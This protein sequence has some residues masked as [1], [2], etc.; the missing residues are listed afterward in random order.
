MPVERLGTV[1][2]LL[3]HCTLLLLRLLLLQQ[4]QCALLLE[5]SRTVEACHLL[6]GRDVQLLLV[7]RSGETLQADRELL[8]RVG[9]MQLLQDIPG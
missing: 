7:A 1:R 9:L 6:L 4:L 5:N 8:G 3:Q 2:N